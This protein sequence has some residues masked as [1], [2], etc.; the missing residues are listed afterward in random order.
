MKKVL[1]AGLML[2]D[3][4]ERDGHDA[5]SAGGM[6]EGELGHRYILPVIHECLEKGGT[7]NPV[8]FSMRAFIQTMPFG[9]EGRKAAWP[10]SGRAQV[11]LAISEAF[12][13]LERE[14]LL[15]RCPH[16]PVPQDPSHIDHDSMVPTRRALRERKGK[17][18]AEL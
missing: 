15:T 11:C 16:T 1:I 6:D 7:G 5:E 12:T 2:A 13:F 17:L 8:N 4:L 10:E 9:L 3:A 18:A 14:G